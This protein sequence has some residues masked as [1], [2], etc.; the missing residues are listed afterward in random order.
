MLSGTQVPSKR[1][2][3]H[4]IVAVLSHPLGALTALIVGVLGTLAALKFAG[5]LTLVGKLKAWLAK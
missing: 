5:P 2:D 1:G 3:P 4:M